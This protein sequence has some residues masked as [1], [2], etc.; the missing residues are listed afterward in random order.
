MF[1]STSF[2]HVVVRESVKPFILYTVGGFVVTSIA[3]FGGS[4][5]FIYCV[6][7]MIHQAT[8]IKPPF[9]RMKGGWYKKLKTCGIC[10]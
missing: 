9:L 10:M 2:I 4:L 3:C 1:L 5:T 6:Y 7:N 8:N